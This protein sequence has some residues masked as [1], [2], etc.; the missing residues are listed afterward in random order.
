MERLAE[1]NK[2]SDK[3]QDAAKELCPDAYFCPTL[4]YEELMVEFIELALNDDEQWTSYFA[5]ERGFDLSEPCVMDSNNNFIP[6][7]TW[8]AVY[9]LIRGDK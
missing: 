6:T 9:D 2:A 7:D 5:W 3:L 1:L 8:G 4:L